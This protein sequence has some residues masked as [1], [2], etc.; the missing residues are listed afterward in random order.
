MRCSPSTEHVAKN[1]WNEYTNEE[2]TMQEPGV[3]NTKFVTGS[4][5]VSPVGIV[6]TGTG[7]EGT[8]DRV[9]CRQSKV[10]LGQPQP[11]RERGGLSPNKWLKMYADL[12]K[13]NGGTRGFDEKF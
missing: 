6:A 4:T 1:P 10:L 2:K 8:V 3:W 5:P 9:C 7:R 12:F 11:R 13:R